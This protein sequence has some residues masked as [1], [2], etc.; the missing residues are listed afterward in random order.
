M[1]QK[2]KPSNQVLVQSNLTISPQAWFDKFSIVICTMIHDALCH[3]RV[4]TIILAVYVDIVVTGDHHQGTSQWKAYLSSHFH[5]KNLSL[6]QYILG[7]S[8][9][10]HERSSYELTKIPY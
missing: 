3:S 5:M 10:I 9:S 4:V 2:V 1:T 7:L 6:L 8:C